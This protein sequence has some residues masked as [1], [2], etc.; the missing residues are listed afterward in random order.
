MKQ[1]TNADFSFL[2]PA[3]ELYAY[4]TFLKEKHNNTGDIDNASSGEG[5]A[6]NPLGG[7]LGGYSSSSS[8]D[9]SSAHL[10]E[11]N[12]AASEGAEGK[13]G[14]AASNNELEATEKSEVD[15]AHEQE[16]KRKRLER[17]RKWKE[18]QLRKDSQQIDAGSS[19][20]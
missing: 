16:K 19:A 10:K 9:D 2:N 18:S 4:Y 15:D 6:N 13:E 3:D 12:K 17:L 20:N 14:V 1:A 5:E 8:S 7:L 11:D